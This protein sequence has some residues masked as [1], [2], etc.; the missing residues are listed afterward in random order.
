[1]AEHVPPEEILRQT[2]EDA[3][4]PRA[5]VGDLALLGNFWVQMRY[6]QEAKIQLFPPKDPTLVLRLIE[7]N[8]ADM[9]GGYLR[10]KEELEYRIIMP[11]GAKERVGIASLRPGRVGSLGRVE[12]WL[13]Y[14]LEPMSDPTGEE[15]D[16]ALVSLAI[17]L[18][19]REDPTDAGE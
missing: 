7:E 9:S 18:K 4:R 5:V 16:S 13:S 6:G 2:W 11:S 17:Y 14:S 19:W 1:M 10:S 12:V 15:S 8:E 3:E